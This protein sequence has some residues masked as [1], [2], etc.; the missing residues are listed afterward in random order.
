MTTTTTTTNTTTRAP[1]TLADVEVTGVERLSPTFLRVA[2]GGAGLADFGV[3]GPLLDQ[4]IKLIVPSTTGVLPDVQDADAAWVARWKALPETERGHMRT[5]TV[6]EVWGAGAD[7]QVV[8]DFALHVGGDI[9]PG[10]R[11]AMQAAPG[12]RAVLLGPRRG[13]AFGGIEFTGL[14][15]DAVLLVGDETAL[16]AIAGILRDLPSTSRGDVV[17][18]VPHQA[19]IL[20][21]PGPDGLTVHWC[22]RA[23]GPRGSQVHQTVRRLAS[24]WGVRGTPGSIDSWPDPDIWETPTY[25]SSG[26]E[27]AS[28]S[29]PGDRYAW[30]AGEATLVTGLRRHLVAEVGLQRCQVAFMGYWREGV[31]MRG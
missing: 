7:T 18:E 20:P 31:A 15:A 4:R 21:L 17:I 24:R 11:W 5:Y 3:D 25:S 6:R 8:V 2:L 22:P 23:G 1:F 9:G 12:G 27:L 30:I 28:G 13:V 10:T 14:D 26:A 29:A 19:D 16:P